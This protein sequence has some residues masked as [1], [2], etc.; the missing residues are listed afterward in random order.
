M[1]NCISGNSLFSLAQELD[2]SVKPDEPYDKQLPSSNFVLCRDAKGIPTATYG[3]NNWDFNPYRLSEKKLTPIYFDRFFDDDN[4]ETKSL[5]NQSKWI[6][7]CLIYFSGKGTLGRIGASTLF[8]YSCEIKRAARYC[9]STKD[10]PLI[11]VISLKELFENFVYLSAFV[12]DNKSN[13][14][15]NKRI[16]SILQHCTQIGEGQLGYKVCSRDN[17]E[18]GHTDSDQR[19]II[20]SGIYLKMINRWG[21]K[22]NDLGDHRH[23]IRLFIE[24]FSDKQYGRCRKRQAEIQ[25]H[26]EIEQYRY[27]PNITDALKDHQ[28]DEVLS[29]FE[30]TSIHS[31]MGC[32]SAIQQLCKNVIHLY[33]A[34][35]DQ[36][37]MRLYCDCIYDQRVTE[38]VL[39]NNM[40]VVDEGRMISVISTTTKYSGYKK[41]AAWLAPTEVK[42]AVDLAR[43]ISLGLFSLTGEEAEPSE[44]PLFISTKNIVTNVGYL[45]STF[46]HSAKVQSL[47]KFVI[48][49]KDFEELRLSDPDRDFVSDDR[50]NIGESWPISSHQFRRSLAFYA[51]SSGFISLPGLRKQFHHLTRQM[52][53][54]YRNGFERIK[55]IFGSWDENKKEF[56]LLPNHFAYEFQTGISMNV[57]HQ[58]ISD[59]IGSESSFFGATGSLIEQQKQEIANGNISIIEFREETIKLVENGKMAYRK[60]LFG[61]CTSVSNCNHFVL[62]NIISCLKCPD[63]IIDKEKLISMIQQSKAEMAEYEIGSAEYRLI[64]AELK[65]MHNYY[66]TKIRRKE[67]EIVQNG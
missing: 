22:L 19:A 3:G 29:E 26:A 14:G 24:Q 44:I 47:F 65:K 50:F 23:S 34:M 35:R 45:S 58:I 12:N 52:T 40:D 21:S 38:D 30:I 28:L 37:V 43:E 31:F 57:A 18:F 33:T 9:Y 11:G 16:P 53:Q 36:E 15:F 4:A 67:L 61:G 6:L 63:S 56:V 27:T 54:Y 55:T 2:R 8:D 60:S 10:N 7:F 13:L 51:S 62:G 49:K 1:K 25:K 66:E 39:G 32:L 64:E 42:R 17:L 59:V 41:E 46:S 5:M 48:D 20:P